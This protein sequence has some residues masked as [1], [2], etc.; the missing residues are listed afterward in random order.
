MLAAAGR[1]FPAG[2]HVDDGAVGTFEFPDSDG[3]VKIGGAIVMA[4]FSAT[5]LVSEEEGMVA[6]ATVPATGAGTSTPLIFAVTATVLF[7]LGASIVV[8]RRHA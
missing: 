8:S 4:R 6:P 1:R 3:P 5:P 7:A 2:Q